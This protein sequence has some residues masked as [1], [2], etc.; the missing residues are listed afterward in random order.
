MATVEWIQLTIHTGTDFG[1]VLY[2][3]KVDLS[4]SKKERQKR[5]GTY[6]PYSSA[7]ARLAKTMNLTAA[8]TPFHNAFP[9]FCGRF[10]FFLGCC[11]EAMT[12]TLRLDPTGW[13]GAGSLRGQ[14]EVRCTGCLDG[15]GFAS[16]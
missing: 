9:V 15:E 2:T 8:A 16:S 4:I 14:L 12:P 10:S 1:Y 11:L 6:P 5:G 3:C 7:G 13:A